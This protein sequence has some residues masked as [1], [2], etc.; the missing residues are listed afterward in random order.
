M[1]LEQMQSQLTDALR[2]NRDTVAWLKRHLEESLKYIADSDQSGHPHGYSVVQIPTWEVKQ[3]LDWL[4]QD[5]AQCE[6]KTCSQCK[7]ES[8]TTDGRSNCDM[9]RNTRVDN[10]DCSVHPNLP[11][12][13]GH[14]CENQPKEAK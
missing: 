9:C 14:K 10:G 4:E 13:L 6:C 11:D 5:A 1:T 2:G 3:K 7:G 12:P 8:G